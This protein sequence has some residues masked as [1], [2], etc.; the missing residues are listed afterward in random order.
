MHDTTHGYSITP[1]GWH[2]RG[3]LPHFDSPETIQFVTFRLVDSLPDAAIHGLAVRPDWLVET[4][5]RL[6]AGLGD[7]WLR[8]PEIARLVEDALLHFDGARYRLLA[9]CVMPNHVHAVREPTER[10]G[11]GGIVASWNSF[12]ARR[13]NLQLGRRGPFW[14]KDY[15]DRYMRTEEHLAR[16]IAYVED[17]PV[18]AGL[19]ET[20]GAWQWSSARP[21]CAARSP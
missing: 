16:T 6:D 15:F 1:K 5:R 7:C 11:L 4:D 14:H 10:D 12:T 17:N 3:Y 21:G 9:W 18:R 19:V 8:H 20:A 2:S 13:A